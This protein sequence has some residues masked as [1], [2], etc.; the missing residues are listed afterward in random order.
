MECLNAVTGWKLTLEDVFTIGRRVIN[1]LR[2]F[3]FR[4]GMKKEDERPSTRYGSVPA[5]GP[6]EGKNIMEKWDWMIE[7]YYT[8]MGWD[9]KTGKP[10]PKTLE[11]LGLEELITDV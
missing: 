4:H 8:L 9:P 6:A 5:D 3:N 11:K 2:V 10:L 1:Q 7:N